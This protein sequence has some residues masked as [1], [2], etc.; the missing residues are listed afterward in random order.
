MEVFVAQPVGRPRHRPTPESIRQAEEL[1]GYG[2]PQDMI[3]RVLGIGERTLQKYYMDALKNGEAHATAKVAQTLFNKA[4]VHEDLGACIFWLK[5]RA[6][7]REREKEKDPPG[8]G[9]KL[10]PVNPETG[11]NAPAP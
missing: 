9:D 5:A 3:A 4:T 11:Y 6:K 10:P 8:D 1:S 7:W 2:L